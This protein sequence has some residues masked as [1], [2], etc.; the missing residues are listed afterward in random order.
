MQFTIFH[1]KVNPDK[2]ILFK[3]NFKLVLKA[4]TNADY[5]GSPVGRQFIMNYF[6][7]L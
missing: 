4:Y 3:R 6:T 1:L 2:G 5:A 7:F